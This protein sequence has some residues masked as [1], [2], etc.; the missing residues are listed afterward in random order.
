MKTANLPR[1][2]LILVFGSALWCAPPQESDGEWHYY[3]G[4][5]ASSH[6]SPLTQI[7]KSNVRELQIAWEWKVGDEPMPQYNITPYNFEATPLMVDDVLYLP[8]PYHRVVALDAKTGK[9][10]WNYDPHMYEWGR[11]PGAEGFALHRG[12]AT[13]TDGKQRRI[14][15]PSR[16][17]LIALDV[18]TG[19]LIPSFGREGIVDMT[20]TLVRKVKDRTH[21]TNTS[22]PVVFKNLV[23]VGSTISDV[24][25]YPQNP[26]G[27]VQA[28]DVRTGKFVWSFHTIPQAGEFGNDS[29]ENESWKNTGHANVWSPMALDE[30]RGLV[31]LPV[32]EPSLDYY[33][34]KRKGNNLFGDTLVCLD[35]NTGKRVWHFQ[36]IHHNLW[37]YDGVMTPN[38]LTIHVD[39]KTI[40]AVAAVSKTGFTYVFNRVTGEPVWP[41]VERPV[42]QSDVP[43]EKTSPTQ[44][45]PTK[46]PAFAHQGF[47][48]DDVVDFTPEIKAMALEKIKD[49]RYG[50]LFNPPSF[51]GTL[52]MPRNI[53]GANWGGAS[54][55][56]EKGILY[57]RAL[58][59]L[60]AIRLTK[61]GVEPE[62]EKPNFPVVL[63]IGEGLFVNKPPY[64]T[65]TAID[66]N[67]GEIIWQVP[68]GDMPAIRNNPLLKGLTLPPTGVPGQAGTLVTASGLLFNAPGDNKLYALDQ[69]NGTVLWAGDLKNPSA[70]TSMVYRTGT[71]MTY[72]TRSGQQFVVL[73]TG[74]EKN[75]PT[76]VAYALPEKSASAPAASSLAATP[77]LKALSGSSQSAAKD[78]SVFLP[79]DR[80]KPLAVKVCAGCHGLASMVGQRGDA[81]FWSDLVWT[82]VSSGA[83]ISRDEADTLVKYFST[84][85]GP[86]QPMLAVPINL[87]TADV[88]T[89]RLL[90]PLAS[91]AE[92]IVKTRH[93]LKGFKQPEDLLKVK[94][95][96]KED[97]EKVRPFISVAAGTERR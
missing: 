25:V 79:E 28:F 34:G 81:D 31:Y 5:S 29:W 74:G 75:P 17:R 42:P 62:N 66:L 23:I 50:P 11:G 35:A 77:A 96:K 26:P 37:D 87:D 16:G 80:A 20:E 49:Y 76:L 6:Y 57:V 95:I 89:L 3:G 88:E 83:D 43:G 67:K 21:Y 84:Y 15:L 56:P 33:G 72:R 91:N 40:D 10:L 13:W 9:E 94:G 69:D 93:E 64:S 51:Q 59:M 19:K 46:P 24:L 90:S 63:T 82:M 47:T 70:G 45:F 44:P 30:K 22:P 92:N 36:V 1:I 52:L 7:N 61:E 39:G 53:G 55:D 4:D 73:A 65:L 48:P 38:L 78:W 85:L 8:T 41:I 71:P 97:F 60:Q 54:V 2:L 12:V 68:I 32:T 18:K 14:L 86:G 58:N 27:D